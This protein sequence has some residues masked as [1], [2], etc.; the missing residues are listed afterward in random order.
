[1]SD[2]DRRLFL[3]VAKSVSGQA[4]IDRLD[5]AQA[6]TAKAMSQR[7]DLS[8]LIARVLAVRNVPLDDTAA[9]LDPTLRDLMPDPSTLMGMDALVEQ[10]VTAIQDE[11]QIALFGDYDV[12]GATSCAQM[13]RFLRH[14][15]LEPVVHI[16]DRIFEG[17]GPNIDAIQQLHDDG[18]QVLIT[19]DCGTTSF[20]PLHFARELGMTV[21]VIDHHLVNGTLPETD[22]L[23]NPNRPDDISGLGNLCA[24]GVTFMVLV[25]VNRALREAG[26]SDLPDLLK[27]LDLVA[28][29]SVCDVVPLT[30][31]NR[32]FVVRGLEQLG[33]RENAG[34]SA[35]A[36]TARVSGPV[37]AYHLGFV[38]GPRIN[39]GGRIGDAGMGTQLLSLDDEHD[40]L[41]IASRLDILNSERQS[42]EATALE[43]A[44]AVADA[45]I[46]DGEGPSVLI[47]TSKDWH[48]GILGLIAARLKERFRRP[49]FAINFDPSGKGTGSGRSVPKV[50]LGG[51]VIRAVEMGLLEKGG[52]HPMAA[53]ITMKQDRLQELRA[54]FESELADD[55]RK[56]WSDRSMHI[57]GALTARAATPQLVN[58]L[59]KAGPF[60]SGNPA[61]TFVLP[62][63]TVSFS[64]VVGKGGHVRAT[65]KSG[66]GASIKAIAFRAVDTPIGAALLDGRGS[67]PLHIAG[68]LDID[69]WQGAERVQIRIRD[70]AMPKYD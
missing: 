39:A 46:G 26:R 53:G 1:M 64:D 42:L 17:Y 32:A 7:H 33:R 50:D 57:D 38:L 4:W 52:G 19:L 61:P 62:A 21:L 18:A 58:M 49:A 63:H 16:P 15:G 6:R 14:L 28:L 37:S 55:V 11:K 2:A 12:D 67:G 13:Q 35:L 34:L 3:N 36:M 43:E 48:P 10:L 31:L 59:E 25:A 40:A 47:M 51:A 5:E 69:R 20:E 22:G 68:T 9:Y 30:G 66:D 44:M 41:S 56:S 29:G 45:E 24:A 54:F 23:V 8:E 60:G 27:F 65:L 70:I